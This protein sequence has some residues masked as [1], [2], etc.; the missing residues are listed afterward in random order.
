[1]G[2]LVKDYLLPERQKRAA[3]SNMLQYFTTQE[4]LPEIYVS[5]LTEIWS[6]RN[7]FIH[8]SIEDTPS[9]KDVEK[10]INRIAD[11]ISAI[12]FRSWRDAY[13]P[14][15]VPSDGQ[16]ESQISNI[17]YH[18]KWGL[19]LKRV[20]DI[21]LSLAVIV[22]L[23]PI[24]VLIA[25]A[26]K[27]DSKGPIIWAQQRVGLLGKTFYMFKFRTM[28]IDAEERL[29]GIEHLNEASGPIYKITSDPRIT[30]VGKLLRKT[31]VDELPQL[32][33]VLRGDMSIVGPRPISL[34]DQ[35]L[36][37]S[38]WLKTR[39]FMR[40]GITC[41]WQISGRSN[42]PFEKWIEL[43]I[44]Y[45]KEWSLWLDFVILLKSIFSLTTS[46]GL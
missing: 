30:R 41:L 24:F 8:S 29:T 2:T 20:F 33:N 31:S 26:I 9:K 12:K 23:A 19:R 14:F 38:G 4:K 46:E 32:I 18:N 7:G 10:F 45:I 6:T 37:K 15:S 11:L 36:F 3:F 16:T 39:I 27:L 17:I 42:L 43:D 40:P 22:I 35:E 13:D 5:R 25:A 44:Q 28:Y 34:R 1:M 21:L